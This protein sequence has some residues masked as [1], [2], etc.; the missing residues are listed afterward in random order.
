LLSRLRNLDDEGSWRTFF[1]TYWRLI[2]NVARQSGLSD[3]QAQDLVQ[4]T[5]I[6]VARKIPGFR[7]DPAK[8]SFKQWLRLMTRRPDQYHLQRLCRSLRIVEAASA[9]SA[10]SAESAPA[11]TLTPDEEID[12]AWEE[13][14]QQNILERALARARQRVHPKSFQLFDY[15]VL[16]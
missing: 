14:W 16:Q 7:Y 12:A 10:N 1:E 2:Y 3:D 13:A 8:G 15:C 4:E 6:A 5:V 11:Q 9:G